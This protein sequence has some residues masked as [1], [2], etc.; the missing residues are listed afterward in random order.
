MSWLRNCHCKRGW[1]QMR[2]YTPGKWNLKTIEHGLSTDNDPPEMGPFQVS[3]S[4]SRDL[5]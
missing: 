5:R 1:L 2:S 4:L 3:G